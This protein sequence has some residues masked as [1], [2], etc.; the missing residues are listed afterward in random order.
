VDVGEAGV[1]VKVCSVSSTAV[2]ES[3]VLFTVSR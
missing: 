3:R 1:L 2:V